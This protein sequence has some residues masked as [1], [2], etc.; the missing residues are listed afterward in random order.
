VIETLS[1]GGMSLLRAAPDPGDVVNKKGLDLRYAWLTVPLPGSSAKITALVEVVHRELCGIHE[2]VRVRFEEMSFDDRV[3]LSDYL[4]D[5][6]ELRF[7]EVS[8][9]ATSRAC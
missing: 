3:R 2:L 7:A 1:T 8:A 9:T 5:Q 4:A 6:D